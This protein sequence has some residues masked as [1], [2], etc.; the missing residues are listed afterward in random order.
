MNGQEIDYL[1]ELAAE[2]GATARFLFGYVYEVK[3]NGETYQVL[4]HDAIKILKRS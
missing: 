4:Y 3:V 1:H 2:K